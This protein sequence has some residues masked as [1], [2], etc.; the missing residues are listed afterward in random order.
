MSQWT[1]VAGV[2][3]FDDLRVIALGGKP[4]EG[5]ANIIEPVPSGSEGPILWDL[6]EAWPQIGGDVQYMATLTFVG[7]L[8]DFGI[9]EMH[10]IRA[11]LDR[12]LEDL[13]RGVAVRGLAASMQVESGPLVLF[14]ARD[15]LLGSGIKYTLH[16]H[17]VGA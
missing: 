8:R 9:P 17:E 7:D 15:E 16:E 3:R 13:P 11:W 12:I 2:I 6:E 10:E 1:H 5:L 14:G 4:G